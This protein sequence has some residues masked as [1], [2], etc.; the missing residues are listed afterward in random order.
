MARRIEYLGDAV[1]S[2][3]QVA[4]QV[5]A[6]PEDLQPELIDQIVI[7][8][9]TGQCESRTGAAIRQALYEEDWPVSYVSGH[10]LDM[11]Q[12][13][14]VVSVGVIQRDGSVT[15]VAGPF[16][17]RRGQRESQLFFPAGRPVGELRIRYKAGVD[18]DQYPSVRSWLLMAADTAFQH[19]GLMVVGQTLA[20]LPSSFLDHLLADITVPPRF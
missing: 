7:P 8:G 3:A 20:E 15:P 6:E 5:R 19:R 16:D 12:A 10:S 1:L 14:E 2:L 4:Y 11:G 17:L 13:T 9:V 18:L